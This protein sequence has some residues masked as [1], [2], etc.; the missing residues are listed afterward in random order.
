MFIS[1]IVFCRDEIARS[2]AMRF[3]P[4]IGSL[5]AAMARLVNRGAIFSN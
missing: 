5:K 2:Q 1:A 3:I 4:L